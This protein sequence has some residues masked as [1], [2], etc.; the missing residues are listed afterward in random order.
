M[1]FKKVALWKDISE[2]EWNDWHWQL[3]NSIKSIKEL[4]EILGLPLEISEEIEKVINYFPM[5]ITP[6]YLMVLRNVIE[7]KGIDASLPLMRTVLPSIEE[8]KNVKEFIDG[9]GE[10][11]TTPFSCVSRFYPDRALIFV[12]S[13]CPCYCRYCFR[14]RK[15]GG[16]EKIFSKDDL[17]KA[18]EYIKKSPPREGKGKEDPLI[19]DVILSGGDPLILDDGNLEWIFSQIREI[20]HVKILRIDTKVPVTLPQRITDDLVQLLKKYK[21]YYMIINFVHPYEIT[22]EVSKVCEKLADA[23]IQLAS[24]TPLLK[25]VNDSSD[26]IKELMLN[27]VEI[28]V[29]PYYLIQFI[30]TK[31]TEHFRTSI[32]KGIKI[33]EDIWG[34]ISGIA[35]PVYIV[36]LPHGKGKV[37][38]YPN[39]IISRVK[40]GYIFRNFE[41]EEVLYYSPLE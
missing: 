1:D 17:Q 27:L 34:Y 4:K 18:I 3:K 22:D 41:N 33:I 36:Y 35:N 24:H 2:K 8:L 38:V 31:W 15:V 9:V 39:Y 6:Y 10:E 13:M 32:T 29:R 7:N 25:G 30:P 5:S 26:V 23:G 19:R 37:P 12:T 21:V 28:R 11:G 40:E 20:P 16:K 14:R